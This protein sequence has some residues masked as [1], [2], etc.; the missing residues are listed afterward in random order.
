[1]RI[2]IVDTGTG[3][4]DTE[5]REELLAWARGLNL[6]TDRACTRFVLIETPAGYWEAHFSLHRQRDGHDYVL[7]GTNRI[8][9]DYD[10]VVRMAPT[11][12]WPRW[13]GQPDGE[14]PDLPVAALLEALD[15][16]GEARL[17]LHVT[18]R[19]RIRMAAHG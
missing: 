16:A 14:M 12:D 4:V 8:A 6:D 2:V 11:N 15:V 17:Q 7:P 3:D 9:V 18:A 1:M 13:F 10:S 19:R 5:M